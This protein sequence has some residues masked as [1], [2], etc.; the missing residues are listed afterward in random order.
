VSR[1]PAPTALKLLN[2]RSEGRDSGGRIVPPVPKF[3]RQAPE[4][5][6][7]LSGEARAEWDRVVPGLERL[8]LLKVE[9]RAVLVAYCETWSRF[10]AA[11]SMYRSEGETIVNPDSGNMRRHPAVGIASEAAAQLKTLAGEFGL[12]PASE[13][14]LS[15]SL[16]DDA[17][18]DPF[19][20]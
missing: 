17:G 13:R 20:Q 7:W 5:P 16:P 3:A 12:T 19:S 18:D 4:P 10:V 2:G 9:D 8:D 1:N 11:V 14:H 6:E 15:P